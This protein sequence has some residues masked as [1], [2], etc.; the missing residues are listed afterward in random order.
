MTRENSTIKARRLVVEARVR[1]RQ[2][3]EH[4]GLVLAE[5]R[6]DSGRVYPVT[7]R[8]GVWRCECDARGTCSHIRAA[9]LVVVTGGAA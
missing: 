6:G 8:H 4:A 2:V 1:V 5:V 7:Y 3:D 9:M